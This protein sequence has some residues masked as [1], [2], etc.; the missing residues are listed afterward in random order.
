MDR[1]PI[2]IFD[3]G[4]GGLTVLKKLIE[5]LPHENFIYLGDTARVPYGNKSKETV[6][7]FAV[8][9]VRFLKKFDIKLLVIACNTVSSCGIDTL[10]KMFPFP[11]VGVIK[12]AVKE[13]CWKTKNMKIGVIGTRAT[14]N[15]AS[16]I[17]GIKKINSKIKVYQNACPLF[18]PLVEENWIKEKSTFDIAKKY[19]KPLM[20]KDIDTLILG[21]THYPLLKRVF[22]KIFKKGI[23]IVDSAVSVSSEIKS[24]LKKNRLE[25]KHKRGSKI[26]FFVTDEPTHFREISRIFLKRNI[27][28]KK[29][30]LL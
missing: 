11:V 26:E 15:S 1:R 29:I 6:T 12:P 2:G 7:R 21:C 20:I 9:C 18:V 13:A 23:N 17:N 27:K 8:E 19:L 25:N 14:V 4:I 30:E 16:Y 24:F 3:S 22:G 10:K 28:V 5:L